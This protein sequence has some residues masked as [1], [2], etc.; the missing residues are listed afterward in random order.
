MRV[1]VYCYLLR[2]YSFNYE[3]WSGRRIWHY[4]FNQLVFWVLCS[5]LLEISQDFPPLSYFTSSTRWQ[6]RANRVW[7]SDRNFLIQIF[8][9]WVFTNPDFSDLIF[10][11]SRLQQL[12]LLQLWSYSHTHFVYTRDRANKR[13]MSTGNH[14]TNHWWKRVK[15]NYWAPFSEITNCQNTNTITCEK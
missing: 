5:T 2:Y 4:T 3:T 14:E 1:H 12:Q 13:S 10:P 6:N 7:I 11:K 15:A 9:F 8:R